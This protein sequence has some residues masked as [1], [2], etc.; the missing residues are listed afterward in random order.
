MRVLQLIDSLHSG[1]AERVAV[2]IANSL[3]NSI[4]QSLLCSTREEGILRSSLNSDVKYLFLE[5]R[6]ILD[7]KAIYKLNKFIKNEKI[8][9]IHAHSTSYFLATIIKLLNR[10]LKIVWHDHYGNS[11]FLN[12]RKSLVLK[13]CS[14]YFN[15]VFCVNNKLEKWSRGY[16]RID[17][18]L[19][20]PNFAVINEVKP[21]TNLLGKE[22]KRII[23]LANLRPQKD[24]LTLD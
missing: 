23:C 14:K 21:Q 3:V 22:G 1:G 10:N 16:L 4:D 18:V 2:N 20:L 7:F 17:D 19:Y 13:Y 9:I 11:E 8:D 6:S 15:F 24:H 5:K 12:K